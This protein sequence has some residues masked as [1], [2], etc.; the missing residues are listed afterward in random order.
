MPVTPVAATDL[1]PIVAADGITGRNNARD[2]RLWQQSMLM[3]GITSM[4][5]RA[6]VLPRQWA[7]GTGWNDGRNVAAGGSNTIVTV[8]PAYVVIPR[9]GQA[10]YLWMLETATNVTLSNTDP[11]NPRIDIV[12]ATAY[13]Q[14]AFP[15]DPQH[16]AYI[17][18]V[19][20]TPAGSPVAPTVPT[21]SVALYQ[22]LR[23]ANNNTTPGTPTDVRLS[24]AFQGAV[25]QLMTDSVST[26]GN[27]FGELRSRPAGTV[28][29]FTE[30]WNGT[31]WVV[32]SYQGDGGHYWTGTITANGDNT[33]YTCTNLLQSRSVGIATLTS[34]TTVKLNSAAKWA[35][36]LWANSGVG[37]SGTS[38]VKIDWP[39]GSPPPQA[40]SD[41]RW[42][43]SGFSGA[44]DLDQ[45]PSWTGY[46]LPTAAA[47][48][49]TVKAL[50][51]PASAS[52]ATFNITLNA[53]YLGG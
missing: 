13:D 16:G 26:A 36:T 38:K 43:G 51:N 40:I 6:G 25:R 45:N 39:G 1:V 18:V 24:A 10:D 22:W 14:V 23:P 35:L 28:G 47:A 29:Q 5:G 7:S 37:A 8:N 2:I 21:G 53:D 31:L 48:G 32:V 30:M 11:T 33:W 41:S 42:R 34:G 4:A 44:G 49:M 19:E 17:T 3:P 52:S 9:S 46:V 50:W 27:V 12:C 20:G 15:G